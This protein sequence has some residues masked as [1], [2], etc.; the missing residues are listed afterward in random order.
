MSQS[1]YKQIFLE[2]KKQILG[3]KFNSSNPFPSEAAV[4]REKQ[5]TRNT[6]HRAFIELRRL[7]LIEGEPGVAP[8]VASGKVSRKIGLIVPGVAYSEFFQP[9]VGEIS[10]LTQEQGYTL[11]FGNITSKDPAKRAAQAKRFA[12]DLVREGVAGVICQPLEFVEDSERLNQEILSIFD[13][14]KVAVVLI[15]CDF[16][17]PPRRSNY[18]A[19]GINNYNAGYRLG[20]LLMSKKAKR[21]DYFIQRNTASGQ[22]NRMRGLTAAVEAKGGKVRALAASPDDLAGVRSHLQ[23]GRPDAFFCCDDHAA[24]LLMKT[25]AKLGL[26]VPDDILLAGFNDVQI[27]SLTMPGLTTIHQPCEDIAKESFRALLDR[28]AD[29]MRPTREIYLPAPLVER[30]STCREPRGQ[31]SVLV[32][33]NSTLR[34]QTRNREK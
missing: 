13:A 29:R 6:V 25:L 27:A 28:I 26:R 15:D 12:K 22:V 8:R 24:A 10:R 17:L 18:D 4:A 16:V 31:D 19:V 32:E 23:G 21:V 33:R 1:K 7:G 9:I 14:A 20:D 30:G 2:L 11:L 34:K 3:A 5:T